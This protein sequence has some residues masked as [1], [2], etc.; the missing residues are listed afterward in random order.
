MAMGEKQRPPEEDDDEKRTEINLRI[1]RE[2]YLAVRRQA[3]AR[4]MSANAWICNAIGDK[5]EEA[6][7]TLPFKKL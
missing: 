7:K 6:G 4:G 5:L 1:P 3:N 2:M